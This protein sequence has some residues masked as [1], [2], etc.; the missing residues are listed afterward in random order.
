LEK[1]SLKLPS[2]I[3]VHKIATLE[4]SLVKI[5]L[6]QVNIEIQEMVKNTL[7]ILHEAL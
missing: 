7:Q 2:I 4:K 6:G 1:S 5:K 3:R